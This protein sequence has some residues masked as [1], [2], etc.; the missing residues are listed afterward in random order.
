[1]EN[2]EKK[3]SLGKL[4]HSWENRI[5]MIINPLNVRHQSFV[6]L[7]Q[8]PWVFKFSVIEKS[9]YSKCTYFPNT[10][11]WKQAE[12]VEIVAIL[13]PGCSCYQGSSSVQNTMPETEKLKQYSTTKCYIKNNMVPPIILY[14]HNWRFK[15]L[16]C[17]GAEYKKLVSDMFSYDVGS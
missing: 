15:E 16:I 14:Q 8:F 12:T 13:L 4:Q 9:Q 17:E 2:P 3:R 5:K 1:M 7:F 11:C 10:T 6:Q